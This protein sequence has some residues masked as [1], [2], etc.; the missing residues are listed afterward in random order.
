MTCKTAVVIGAS[1]GI[2]CAFANAVEAED[3]YDQVVRFSRTSEGP[4]HLDIQSE[5]TI[6]AAASFLKD[7]GISPSLIFVATGLLH[8]DTRGPEKSLRELDQDWLTENYQVNAIGPAL[9][10][11]YFLPL[12]PKENITKF[13]AISA[14]V[15]SISD[16]RLGGWYGYRAAKAALNMMIRNL[17]IE[18]SRKNKRSIIVALHPGTVDTS[19][20]KPFQTNVPPGKLFDPDRA[21]LQLLDVLDGLKPADSGKV[22]AWDG[23][24]IKP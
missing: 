1:G 11:K 4:F 8:S 12:M 7:S 17:A 22:F 21:A 9:V 2:G 16:N 23:E 19:L 13:A 24:E 3:E 6:G 20:S 10:A 18:W 5:Q 14:R 15:G